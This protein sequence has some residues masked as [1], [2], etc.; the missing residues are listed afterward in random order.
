MEPVRGVVYGTVAVGESLINRLQP[1]GGK[2]RT[3]KP[4]V[5]IVDPPLTFEWLGHLGFR[6]LFDGR[7]RFE[8][9]ATS[10]G[11]RLTQIEHF[12]G[13][14]VRFVRRTLDDHTAAGFNAMNQR[15]E[16]P[17]GES[18]GRPAG[19]R[20]MMRR[21]MTAMMRAMMAMA[22]VF[23]C[24]QLVVV[25]GCGRGWWGRGVGQGPPR[26]WSMRRWSGLKPCSMPHRTAWVR[27]VVPILR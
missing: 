3:F 15:A 25:G 22:C 21:T 26:Q 17:C 19:Q 9:T 27:L 6:G 24:C 5:T 14:L 23:M 8:L 12:S 18:H 11:T 16:D 1:A 13:I 20:R 4:T 7:H 10:A 2:P